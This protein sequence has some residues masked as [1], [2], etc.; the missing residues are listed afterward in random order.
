MIEQTGSSYEQLLQEWS[1]RREMVNQYCNALLLLTPEDHD[2]RQ[3]W[4]EPS[5]KLASAESALRRASAQL[6]SY[7]AERAL[8]SGARH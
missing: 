5:G 7:E 2:A 1:F 4:Q 8:S 3:R 6:R